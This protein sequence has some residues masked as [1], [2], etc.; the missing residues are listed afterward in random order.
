MIN[1]PQNCM[2]SATTGQHNRANVVGQTKR[3]TG[4][5][6]DICFVDFTMSSNNNTILPLVNIAIRWIQME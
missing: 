2:D 1:R 6:H 3:L 5:L 4:N